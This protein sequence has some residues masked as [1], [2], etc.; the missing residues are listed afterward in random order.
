[1][2]PIQTQLLKLLQMIMKQVQPIQI[3]KQ[4]KRMK[5]LKQMQAIQIQILMEILLIQLITE[6]M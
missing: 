3:P 2:Q 4:K 1:M 5:I 6:Q